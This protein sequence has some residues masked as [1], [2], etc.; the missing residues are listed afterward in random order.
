MLR[1]QRS[2]SACV[3]PGARRA[4]MRSISRRC[5]SMNCF[6]ITG[7]AALGS[8]ISRNMMLPWMPETSSTVSSR[9]AMRRSSICSSSL[10]RERVEIPVR[11]RTARREPR[12]Q[13]AELGAHDLE[14]ERLLRAEVVVRRGEVDAGALGDLAH[15]RREEAA[16]REQLARGRQDPLPRG[17]GVVV[18]HERLFKSSV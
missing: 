3:S 6:T 11:A 2:T 10:A 17:L 12:L 1:M 7:S 5:G 4:T 9:V 18:S 8:V 14:I 13:L 15:R 16:L